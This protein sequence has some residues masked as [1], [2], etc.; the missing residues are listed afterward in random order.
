M[1]SHEISP[2]HCLLVA[3]DMA[4]FASISADTPPKRASPTSR[5]EMLNPDQGSCSAPP[6]G[7]IAWPAVQPSKK[8]VR[9]PPA[10]LVE[11]PLF[12]IVA[13]A[14]DPPTILVRPPNAPLAWAP[15]FV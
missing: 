14:V 10:P 15:L 5:A 6:L 4:I 3:Y 8:I 7:M 13:F 12:V 2:P 11:A 1:I 9:P